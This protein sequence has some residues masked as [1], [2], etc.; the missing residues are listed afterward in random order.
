MI[1]GVVTIRVKPGK[2]SE[3]VQFFKANA[4]IVERE[5]GC[6]RYMLTADVESGMPVQ[7]ID[8]DVVTLLEE[9][10]SMDAVREHLAAP[11]MAAYFEKEKK[12]V[13]DVAVRMLQEA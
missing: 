6:R 7:V 12:L 2:M 10:E 8:G 5:K 3:F 4:A 1:Y 9:W 11:H 13:N